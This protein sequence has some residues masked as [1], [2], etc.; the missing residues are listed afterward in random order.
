MVVEDDVLVR[1][2][3]AEALRDAGLRVIE[4]SNANEAL[5]YLASGEPVD[6]IFSDIQLTGS[7]GGVD[8]VRIVREKYAHV[9]TVLTSG[10]GAALAEG[11]PH[12]IEKPYELPDAVARIIGLLGKK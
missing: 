7:M 4:A 11:H 6:L 5:G 12:F 10:G 9:I 2:V 8:L 3:I 1:T